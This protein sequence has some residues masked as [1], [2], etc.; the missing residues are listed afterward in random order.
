MNK[1]LLAALLAL[2]SSSAFA[3]DAR[4]AEELRAREIFA[5]LISYKTS[6]GLAQVPSPG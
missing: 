6:V 3:A 1:F 5:R 4:T 2:S